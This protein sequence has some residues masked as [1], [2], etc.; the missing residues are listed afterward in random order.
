M[1]TS[2]YYQ[3]AAAVFFCLFALSVSFAPRIAEAACGDY[4]ADGTHGIPNISYVACIKPRLSNNDRNMVAQGEYHAQCETAAEAELVGKLYT[5]CTGLADGTYVISG[6]NYGFYQVYD[7]NGMFWDNFSVGHNNN[8]N[9]VVTAPRSVAYLPPGSYTA[10]ANACLSNPPVCNNDSYS[11]TVAPLPVDGQ[12]AATRYNCSSPESSINQVDGSTQWTWT[13]PGSNGGS[14]AQCSENKPTIPTCNT[15]ISCSGACTA[16]QN[17]CSVNPPNGTRGSCVYTAHTSGGQCTQAPA[18]DQPCTLSN[19]N[20]GFTC[21]DGNCVQ[22]VNGQCSTVRDNCAVGTPTDLP[23]TDTEY[24]WQCDGTGPDH[25]DAQCSAPIATAAQYRLTVTKTGSGT[26]TTTG[27]DCPGTTTPC[28]GQYDSGTPLTLTG[29]PSTGYQAVVWGGDCSSSGTVTMNAD[30]TC[31]A[32]FAP[33]VPQT[34]L[35]TVTKTGDGRGTV[36][37][38]PAGI[39]CGGDCTENYA[40]DT[41]VT[42]TASASFG[43]Q[44]A[45]WSGAGCSGTGACVVTMS[46]AKTVNAEFMVVA[47]PDSITV[48]GTLICPSD[49]TF[50]WNAPSPTPAGFAGY[51]VYFCSSSSSCTPGRVTNGDDDPPYQVTS[52]RSYY[53]PLAGQTAR[54]FVRAVDGADNVLATSNTATVTN[55]CDIPPQ[56]S[57]PRGPGPFDLSVSGASSCTDTDVDLMPSWSQSSGAY[58]YYLI[59]YWD[60]DGNGTVS[61]AEGVNFST[62]SDTYKCFASPNPFDGSIPKDTLPLPQLIDGRYAHIDADRL[63]NRWHEYSMYSYRTQDCSPSEDGVMYSTPA[64]VRI[65]QSPL[66]PEDCVS[67]L[68]C[69]LSASPATIGRGASTRLSWTT[70]NAASG[71]IDNGVGAMSPMA[72]GSRDVS[73]T[74]STTYTATVT[75]GNGGTAQCRASVGV[76]REPTPTVRLFIGKLGEGQLN[77]VSVTINA[78][79][80]VRLSWQAT[81]ATR[82][83]GDTYFSTGPRRPTSGTTVDEDDVVEPPRGFRRYRVTCYN[84]DGDGA[85]RSDDDAA[86][87][88][89]GAAEDPDVW[90][91][92]TIVDYGGRSA[93]KWRLNGNA[94]CDITGTNGQVVGTNLTADNTTGVAT[95]QLY[96]ETRYDMTCD[97]GVEDDATIRV[98]P[99]FEEI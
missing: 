82:C 8:R 87:D 36:T 83:V 43:S 9:F 15:G 29:T 21:S 58:S 7:Q 70:Q 77:D 23:D 54:L 60:E 37:S 1:R 71:T 97:G 24:R 19:C 35:L 55:N 45:G 92:P 40:N 38:S 4:N 59:R 57:L 79:E 51:R 33:V 16:P 49:S 31:T 86:V 6:A 30:K 72:R 13:C 28:S 76:T 47:P 20:A 96:G 41:Q 26:V 85:P 17:T 62:L 65:R 52:Y 5:D 56:D 32:T 2:L 69:T 18:P 44:F 25:T 84:G 46:A 50:S 48:T 27:F 64:T 11:W 98:R 39:S 53:Y 14:D 3:L 80:H 12:C 94:G 88:V 90:A 74:R 34:H 89:V 68:S 81:N 22:T 61:Y 63:P 75:G 73:P 66:P 67:P 91:E 93:I 99:R 10:K 42:L 95:D 78:G